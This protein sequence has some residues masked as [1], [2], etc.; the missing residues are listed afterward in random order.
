[1]SRPRPGVLPAIILLVFAA[2]GMLALNRWV[3][4]SALPEG[5]IQAS[6]RIEGDLVTVASKFP[7]RVQKLL[8]RE[9]DRVTA[10]QVLIEIEDAQATARVAQA[11]QAL[12][13]L[14]AQVKAARTTLGVLQ[15]EVPLSI[16]NARAAVEHGQAMVSKAEASERQARRDATR[17]RELVVRGTVDKQRSEQAQL[18]WA[19][20]QDELAAAR[21]TLVQGEKQLALARLGDDR[22]EAREDELAALQAQRAQASAVLAEAESVLKDLTIIAPTNGTLTRRLVNTGE[23][24]SA[25]SPLYELVDLD[26]LYLQVYVPEVQIGMLR[27]GLPARIYTDAFP[28][29][30]FEATLRYI[31]SRAEFTPKEVQTPDERVKLVF[32][33]RLYL[34]ANPDHRL[35]PGLPADAMIR[36]KEEVPW[37]K[38][39]W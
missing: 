21:S 26:K 13:A 32:A 5:L 29:R 7:G 15:A 31:S 6:G 10:G 27:L 39:R 37:Q 20:S 11:R 19:V 23:V 16:E 17:L 38:P 4:Q 8:A 24:V 9:G 22:I 3:R 14:D 36:W 25:G 35:T 34:S 33:V 12:S 2:S 18:A 1:M 28:D 30:P